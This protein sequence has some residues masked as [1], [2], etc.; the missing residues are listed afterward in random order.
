MT[1]IGTIHIWL[2]N[3]LNHSSMPVNQTVKCVQTFDCCCLNV[4]EDQMKTCGLLFASVVVIKKQTIKYG[5]WW[6]VELFMRHWHPQM[7][8]NNDDNI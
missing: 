8:V 3:N 7:D 4:Y 6:F 2:Q 1:K 5:L